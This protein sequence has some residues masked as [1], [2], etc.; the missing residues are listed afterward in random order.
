MGETGLAF[1]ASTASAGEAAADVLVLPVYE[2]PDPGPGM[3]EVQK[4]LGADLIGMIREQRLEGKIG[5]TLTIPTLGRIRAA[6]LV[7]TGIG[8]KR[9]AGPNQVRR[10]AMKAARGL[11]G[12]RTAASTLPQ[13]GKPLQE[14]AR[15]FAEGISLGTYNFDRYK[16]KPDKNANRLSAV[17]A[18]VPGNR[19]RTASALE[20]GRIHANA[21]N[22]VRDMVNTPAA[23]ATPA[24]LAKQ[25]QGIARKHG[26]DSKIWNRAELQAGGFGGIIAVGQGSP[27]EP[28]FIE[29]SYRGAGTAK[30]IA[31]TGKGITFDSGGLN[32]KGAKE[33]EWMKA[34]MTG[35]AVTLAVMRA[36]AEMGLRINVIAGIGSAE[37][38][39]SGGAIR[40]GDVIRHRNGKTSEMM[41]TDAEGRV[42][43]ADALSYLVEKKPSAIIDSATLTYT[44]LG[45]DIWSIFGTD[46]DLTDGLLAAGDEAGE[47]GWEMP[48]WEPYKR[49]TKSD[50]ADIKNSSWDG[51]DTLAA[52]LFLQEFTG[53]I[54]W[55][56]LDVAYTAYLEHDR[57]EWPKGPT[58]CPTRVILRYLER[59]A[60]GR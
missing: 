5:D 49:H 9:D 25:A 2:G 34:D 27:K 35:A 32:I 44:G 22:W 14:S 55:A 26:M 39:P 10:A 58:G 59:L 45:E 40:Q 48:L 18:L 52:A 53:D 6:T 7:L 37:N 29:L 17:Q 56:H 42:L 30:P 28:R 3:R 41:H 43:L 12:F 8:P 51:S 36:I 1:E 21:S 20:L 47:P 24:F 60:P 31:I 57:D 11:G 16:S 23:D 38:M 33:M 13:V 15:A 54:P 46:E 4:A 19:A 50:V